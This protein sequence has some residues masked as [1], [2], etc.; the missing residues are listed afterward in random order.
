MRHAR[1]APD[2]ARVPAAVGRGS[3]LSLRGPARRR[4]AEAP[5]HADP[6]HPPH[7]RAPARSSGSAPGRPSTWG[8]RAPSGP[9][10]SRCCGASSRPGGASSTPLPCT[11][12]PSRR[13]ET[14]SPASPPPRA[15]FLATKVWT[16][17]QR[18]GRGADA[19]VDAAAAGRPDRPHAGAQPRSTGETHLASAARLEGAGE[20]P[21]PRRSP[22][23][24]SSA[25]RYAMERITAAGAVDFVQLPYSAG[26][27]RGG[28]AAAPRRG[29]DRDGGARHAAVRGRALCSEGC[30]GKPLPAWAAEIDCATSWAQLFLKFVVSHPAVT[31]AIPAT[32]NPDHLAD[33]VGAG[34]GRL[35]DGPDL[36]RRMAAEAAG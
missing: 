22:T 26:V 27:A 3:T 4:R 36:R 2:A 28:E 19:G 10:R 18:R 15:P 23:T 14:W 13:W 24:P 34:L 9:A 7:R 33:D 6:S 1:F 32:S 16:T 21:L 30:A 11:G 29:R 17:G 25:F 8:R 12:A 31:C 20:D 5:A 35:P